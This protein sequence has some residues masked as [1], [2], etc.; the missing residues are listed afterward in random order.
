[1]P[2]PVP[3]RSACRPAACAAA[4]LGLLLTLAVSWGAAPAAAAPGSIEPFRLHGAKIGGPFTLTDQQGR[5]L[6]LG[7]LQGNAVLLAFGYTHCPDICPLTLSKMT[8]VLKALGPL[9]TSTRMV[10]ITVDPER[11]TPKVLHAYLGFFDARI[12]GL[13]GSLADVQGVATR[14]AAGFKK[15][16]QGSAAGY[17]VNHVGFFYLLD[18]AG[19]VQYIVPHTIDPEIIAQGLRKVL[20]G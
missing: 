18:P 19:K 13:T 11:D 3:S 16:E 10:F 15:V 20:K 1:M 6:S 17:L 8:A 2:R 14:Y 5:P 9:A 4:A 7:Q 12:V